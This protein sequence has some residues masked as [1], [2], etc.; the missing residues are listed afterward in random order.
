P[1]HPFADPVAASSDTPAA[2]ANTRQW[3]VLVGN[4]VSRVNA[5]TVEALT[6]LLI[7]DNLL[8][9]IFMFSMAERLATGTISAAMPL[10]IVST[11]KLVCRIIDVSN[12]NALATASTSEYWPR[13]TGKG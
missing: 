9:S 11:G 13:T 7:C 8:E 5:S 6:S 10:K 1:K 3:T 12:D 4:N 2:G